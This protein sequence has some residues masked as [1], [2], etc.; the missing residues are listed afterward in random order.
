[1]ASYALAWILVE[2]T[3]FSEPRNWL[4][5]KESKNILIIKAQQLF[6]CIYCM[7]FWTGLLCF[8]LYVPFNMLLFYSLSTIT[9][10]FFIERILYV[11][12][13]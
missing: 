11:K 2:A 6:S 8:S 4:L 3:I 1:M 7:S 9:I 5:D 10:T 13:G 12:E